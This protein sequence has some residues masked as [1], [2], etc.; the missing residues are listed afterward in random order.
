MPPLLVVRFLSRVADQTSPS[1]RYTG[2]LA[3]GVL[4]KYT[5]LICPEQQHSLDLLHGG[6][7]LRELTFPLT[8]DPFL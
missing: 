1:N 3:M 8:D 7:R 2:V 6:L 4:L 5:A